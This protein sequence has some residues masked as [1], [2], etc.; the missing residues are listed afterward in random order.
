[1]ANV[2]PYMQFPDV[3]YAEKALSTLGE[4]LRLKGARSVSIELSGRETTE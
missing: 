2:H 4:P 1:M 3:Y